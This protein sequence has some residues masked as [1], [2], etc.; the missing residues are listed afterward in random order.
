MSDLSAW[1]PLCL[2]QPPARDLDY[3]PCSRRTMATLRSK[4]HSSWRQ[5]TLLLS[6]PWLLT[7]RIADAPKEITNLAVVLAILL[8]NINEPSGPAAAV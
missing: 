3:L 5:N 4:M 1:N 8:M 7:N 2:V 6:G